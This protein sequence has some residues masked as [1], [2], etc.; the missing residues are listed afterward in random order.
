ML[1]GLRHQQA[2][3]RI[4]IDRQLANVCHFYFRLR[5]RV[6]LKYFPRPEALGPAY[7]FNFPRGAVR[8]IA[9]SEKQQKRC[10]N[11]QTCQSDLRNPSSPNGDMPGFVNLT[12]CRA[13]RLQDWQ[14]RRQTC[15]KPYFFVNR[16]AFRA[17]SQVR[18]DT[19]PLAG[20]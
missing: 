13:G 3:P 9:P 2:Y 19:Q 7:S 18:F 17:C 14:E 4:V 15:S 10:Q 20:G 8:T 12:P 16:T 5:G 6:R 1:V 11:G